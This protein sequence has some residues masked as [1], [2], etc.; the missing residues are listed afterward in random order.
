MNEKTSLFEA[1]NKINV[2]KKIKEKGSFDYLPW[3][4]AW[5]YMKK[6]DPES[7]EKV[8]WF[9]HH[10]VIG[11]SNQNFLVEECLP[12]CDNQEQGAFVQVDVV[13]KG[14]VETEIFPILNFKNQPVTKPNSMQVNNALKRCFVKALAKHGLGLYIY[15]GEDVPEPPKIDNKTV[16]MIE[17]LVFSLDEATN[18]SNKDNLIDWINEFTKEKGLIADEIKDFYDMTIEQ[19]GLLK[20]AINKRMI[21]IEKENN[22][23]KKA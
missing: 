2:K 17:A 4:S 22:Q 14:R 11:D 5:E 1:L 19:S 9:T 20:R 10:R 13:V 3:A 21:Q 8:R 6:Y 7:E 23:N 18:T 12:Y 15:Q 16:D